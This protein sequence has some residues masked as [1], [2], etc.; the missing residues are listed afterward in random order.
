MI[1]ILQ[2]A[3][4]A[5]LISCSSCSG[6]AGSGGNRQGGLATG[7]VIPDVKCLAHPSYSYAV[8][9]PS[10]YTEGSEIPVYIAFDPHASG[11]LPVSMY[12]DIAEKYGFILMGSN[13]S[14]N[15]QMMDATGRIATAMLTEAKSRF[16]AD[17]SRI[18]L[19][20]F[21][22]GARVAAIV[23][24]FAEKVHGVIGCGA[25]FR[26]TEQ[27]HSFGFDY[28]CIAGEA[29]PN[30]SEVIIQDEALTKAGWRHELL[31]IP[32]GHA[33]PP[34]DAMEKAVLW[35]KGELP[36]LP[37]P[38]VP[39]A[40]YYE[41]DREAKMQAELINHFL[42]GD[43]VW[44]KREINMLRSASSDPN[45]RNDGLIA[46]RLIAFLGLMS[47]SY[48]TSQLNQGLLDQAYRSLVIYRMVEPEN[49]AVDSLFRI[50][51]QARNR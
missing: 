46:D 13:D 16:G 38:D 4:V 51:N 15:G 31:V 20:G 27:Q 14:R 29:D 43:T 28:F 41:I 35:M 1:R 12:K 45:S 25:G 23:G 47:W 44:M 24:M 6:G 37:R 34:A 26:E 5:I 7:T 2:L 36:P 48:S 33:W 18:I 17:S 49:P 8:Y 10:T 3:L 32:G 9:L 11:T 22:G 21:S 39:L 19:T 42:T 30:L 40:T 50:Y